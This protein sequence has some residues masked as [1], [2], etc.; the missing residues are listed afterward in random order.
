MENKNI[1]IEILKLKVEKLKIR[2]SFLRT[3]II[4]IIAIGTAIG[5]LVNKLDTLDYTNSDL[6]YPLGIIFMAIFLFII[7]EFVKFRNEISEIEKE[8]RKD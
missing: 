8:I 2:E 1:D 6:I 4:V 7:Y 3:L 5:V